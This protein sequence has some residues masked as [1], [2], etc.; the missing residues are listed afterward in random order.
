MQG[1]LYNPALPELNESID[2][3]NAYIQTNRHKICLFAQDMASSDL[4]FS[5]PLNIS[6]SDLG[7]NS[8]AIANV[9]PEMNSIEINLNSRFI[10]RLKI[11]PNRSEELTVLTF[12]FR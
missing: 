7:S 5:V 10:N 11:L 2:L 4:A 12:F 6:E 8:Y 1:F 3:A 9:N